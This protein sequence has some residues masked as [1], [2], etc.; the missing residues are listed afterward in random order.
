MHTERRI[1]HVESLPFKRYFEQNTV[2]CNGLYYSDSNSVQRS[3]RGK[4][5]LSSSHLVM[6]MGLIFAH[7]SMTTST[8]QVPIHAYL[9][10]HMLAS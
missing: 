1:Y 10:Q 4:W 5:C 3:Q 6:H 7:K 9:L 2:D 8:K